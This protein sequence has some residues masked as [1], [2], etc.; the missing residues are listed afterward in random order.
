MKKDAL[1]PPIERELL[2]FIDEIEAFPHSLWFA[3]GADQALPNLVKGRLA[4]VGEV[5]V[6]VVA[7]EPDLWARVAQDHRAGDIHIVHLAKLSEAA[8]RTRWVRL[9]LGREWRIAN[10]AHIVLWVPG[11][12]AFEQIRRSAP[13]LWAHRS[14]LL[15]LVGSADFEVD[16]AVADVGSAITVDH[17]L[18]RSLD[19]WNVGEKFLAMCAWSWS[20]SPDRLPEIIAAAARVRGIRS[21]LG[22]SIVPYWWIEA[23][24]ARGGRVGMADAV[25]ALGLDP[26]TTN[27]LLAEGAGDGVLSDLSASRWYRRALTGSFS[28]TATSLACLASHMIYREWVHPGRDLLGRASRSNQE[29]AA[30]MALLQQQTMDSCQIKRLAARNALFEGDPVVACEALHRSLAARLRL[31]QSQQADTDRDLLGAIYAHMGLVVA[32]TS[33]M[34]RRKESAVLTA[35]RL[36]RTVSLSATHALAS[37]DPGTIKAAIT[38][39]EAALDGVT[40]S[41]FRMAELHYQL[42]RAYGVLHRQMANPA[43]LDRAEDHLRAIDTLPD[44]ER[45]LPATLERPDIDDPLARGLQQLAAL[46][47]PGFEPEFRLDFEID[48]AGEYRGYR[49][50]LGSRL[51]WARGEQTKAVELQDAYATWLTDL[52]WWPKAAHAW[53]DLADACWLTGDFDQGEKALARARSCLD[54]ERDQEMDMDLRDAGDLAFQALA[55]A[56][57]SRARSEPANVLVALQRGLQHVRVAG[58]LSR[59]PML[60]RGLARLTNGAL[61]LAAR[62]C[63]A[64]RARDL[65]RTQ[66]DL[67]EETKGT[68]L[69]A[70]LLEKAGRLEEAAAADAEVARIKERLPGPLELSDDPTWKL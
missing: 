24:K 51:A 53:R 22:V 57:I 55:E 1:E 69:L 28:R 41:R 63:Y 42:A 56:R 46:S 54:H 9:N 27:G 47:D 16:D 30:G 39:G 45:V 26:Q 60:L 61:D 25:R 7:D 67:L 15:W 29:Q 68:H 17:R 2:T 23:C 49:L 35:D 34:K 4:E 70:R 38:E 14:G 20:K 50:R 64:R 31:G 8:E 12:H 58:N 65:A 43:D 32:W 36:A 62:I 52:E 66:R 48:P 59:E 44:R 5:H 3:V 19:G 33:V 21:A 37:N 6:H 18:E 10:V 11:L 40:G 13:D